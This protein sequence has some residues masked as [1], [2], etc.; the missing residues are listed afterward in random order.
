MGST[1]FAK[2]SVGSVAN[3]RNGEL[4]RD[5]VLPMRL[6]LVDAAAGS[7]TFYVNAHTADGS[8]VTVNKS[9][10]YPRNVVAVASGAATSVVVVN[11]LDFNGYAI[12]ESFTLNGATPVVGKKAFSKVTNVVLPTTS[13]RTVSVGTGIV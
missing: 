13:G 2:L 11:G 5:A 3:Q 1:N 8:T 4:G 6:A 12:S 7:S 9:A 10:D